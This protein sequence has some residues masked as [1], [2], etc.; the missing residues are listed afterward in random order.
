MDGVVINDVPATAGAIV[1]LDE[2]VAAPMVEA[3]QL[4]LVVE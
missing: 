2:A 4:E 3:G 1:E